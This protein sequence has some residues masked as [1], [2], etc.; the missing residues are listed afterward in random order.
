MLAQNSLHVSKTT[1]PCNFTFDGETIVEAVKD[2][3]LLRETESNI[4]I[5][6]KYDIEAD[7]FNVYTSSE[8][9]YPYLPPNTTK[10]KT[11]TMTLAPGASYKI[12]VSILIRK[13]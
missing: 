13:K 4:T 10:A 7:G 5:S 1:G 12:R 8:R 2:L 9:P 3:M 6:W 11:L